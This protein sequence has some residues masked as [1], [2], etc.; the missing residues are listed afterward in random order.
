[1]RGVRDSFT[2]A[3]YCEEQGAINPKEKFAVCIACERKHPGLCVA[4]CT[5]DVRSMAERMQ[6]IIATWSHGTFF[7]Y[8]VYGPDSEEPEFT[9]YRCLVEHADA[10]SAECE[11]V[12]GVPRFKRRPPP[13][14]DISFFVGITDLSQI[15]LKISI[16]EDLKK[17]ELVIFD[18]SGLPVSSVDAASTLPRLVPPAKK[19]HAL[20][21]S[22]LP[23]VQADVVAGTDKTHVGQPFFVQQM[24]KVLGDFNEHH[25]KPGAEDPGSDDEEQKCLLE[26]ETELQDIFQKTIKRKKGRRK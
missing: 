18:E 22:P 6:N 13:W 7:A 15:A 26:L 2:S 25:K 12:D 4:E 16:I 17:L 20:F 14:N 23:D 1:M 19:V 24:Y 8:R 21:H 10:L 5:G 9:E 11:V 3:L